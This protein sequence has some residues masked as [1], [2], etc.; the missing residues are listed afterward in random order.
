MAAPMNA[1]IWPVEDTTTIRTDELTAGDLLASGTEF[2]QPDG[3]TGHEVAEAGY[4]GW[5][6]EWGQEV[7]RVRRT[8]GREYVQPADFR[9]TVV[10]RDRVGVA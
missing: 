4:A 9:V 6:K 7:W 2:G 3:F 5:S 10:R 1:R 8:D